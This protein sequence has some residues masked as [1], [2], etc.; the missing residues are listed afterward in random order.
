MS[1][2]VSSPRALAQPQIRRPDVQGGLQ[3]TTPP[4]AKWPLPVAFWPLLDLSR[5]HNVEVFYSK[6]RPTQYLGPAE[7]VPPFG[8]RTSALANVVR[9]FSGGLT[10]SVRGGGEGAGTRRCLH[11]HHSTDPCATA[12]RWIGRVF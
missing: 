2:P 10:A 3:A 6:S 4:V 11:E 7:P 1:L 5:S 8:L 9:L 12:W